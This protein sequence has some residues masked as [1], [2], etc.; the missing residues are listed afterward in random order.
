[1]A[2]GRIT[3]EHFLGGRMMIQPDRSLEALEGISRAFGG[4]ARRVA[5]AVVRV[6]NANME[7]ALRVVSVERG[8]DPREFTLVAFGGAGPLHACE[9]ADGLRIPRVLVPPHPGVLS[10][11]GIATAPVVKEL[12]AWVMM[13]FEAEGRVRGAWARHPS[14][15]RRL[16]DDLEARGIAELKAEGFKVRGVRVETVLDMRYAG[17]SYELPVRVRGLEPAAFLRQF[18]RAHR[19]RYGHGDASQAVEVVN[20]RVKLV[21]AAP[22]PSRAGRG[23]QRADTGGRKPTPAE[24][25]EVWFGEGAPRAVETPFFERE[26]LEAGQTLRGPAVVVQMDGT[27]VVAPGWRAEVDALGNLVLARERRA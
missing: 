23:E 2:L 3:P 16:R 1:V 25:R 13:R 12:A 7:S 4:G 8:Y 5:A 17:Q 26:G 14:P 18:H 11:L 22:V 6:A 24:R 20:M 27:T 21:V 19:E 9:L 15:L 10:A